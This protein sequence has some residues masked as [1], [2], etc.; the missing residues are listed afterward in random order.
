MYRTPEIPADS[1]W[2]PE[3]IESLLKSLQAMRSDGL[4]EKAQAL[5][6]RS[7][8]RSD[9]ICRRMAGYKSASSTEREAILGELT[10]FV[11]E[12][13][14]PKEEASVDNPDE[15]KKEFKGWR[16]PPPKNE[17]PAESPW[18]AS[19]T[20]SF[21]FA[22]VVAFLIMISV[23]IVIWVGVKASD[24]ADKRE[25]VRQEEIKANRSGCASLSAS[26]LQRP[27]HGFLHAVHV[28]Q[29]SSVF[30]LRALD[31]QGRS[32]SLRSKIVHE[33]CIH[34]K[35]RREQSPCRRSDHCIEVN[36]DNILNTAIEYFPRMGLEAH[37][38]DVR[39]LFDEHQKQL[40]LI[41]KWESALNLLVK[42][43]DNNRS[44]NRFSFRNQDI[45]EIEMLVER[46]Y[47]ENKSEFEVSSA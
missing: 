7:A 8:L 19:P 22:H 42:K 24:A 32:G 37:I 11:E 14:P 12:H 9:A 20:S 38:A 21:E 13:F 25:A 31:G 1:G 15:P 27:L 34:S 41:R 28:P 5:F 16:A 17:K 26:R 3:L 30:V 29:R 2:S 39:L 45:G 47:N 10:K 33:N 23:P 43:Q 44:F 46:F 4:N 40:P 36:I 6:F 35:L 18:A